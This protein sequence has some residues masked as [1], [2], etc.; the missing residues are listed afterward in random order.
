MEHREILK[1]GYDMIWLLSCVLNGRKPDEERLASMDPALLM[2]ESKRHQISA[3]IAKA[4]EGTS[5]DSPAW[6]N[7]LA[8]SMR[9][10]IL[11]TNER[12]H[13][14]DRLEENA[15]WYMPLKGSVLEKYYPLCGLRE[16]SDADIL[17]DAAREA[18]VKAIMKSEGYSVES[19]GKIHNDT[20][21]KKPI[22]NF[23]MHTSLFYENKYEKLY[24][25]YK[26]VKKRLIRDGQSEYGYCF[27][28]E[29]FYVFLLAHAYKHYS[30]E[31]FGLRLLADVF[32]YQEK[33][34]DLDRDYIRRQCEQL[35]FAEWSDNVLSLTMKAI[36]D[37]VYGDGIDG[38]EKKIMDHVIDS[39]AF[40]TASNTIGRKVREVHGEGKLTLA[41]KLKYLWSRL[42]MP[43][44]ALKMY[45]PYIYKHR[46]LRPFFVIYR[47]FLAVFTKRN[48]IRAEMHV[49]RHLDEEGGE[50][51]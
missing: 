45:H 3:L 49:L 32:V 14:L 12:K 43:E 44:E 39:R 42:I 16:M 37:G 34:P 25:Y 17:F 21:H 15:I 51:S 38:E 28:A 4:L 6:Q 30:H 20:Y 23:E 22:Y 2:K 11:F 9:R 47:F 19:Y 10:S 7:L 5:L 50:E 29:D 33:E 8:V 48:V 18:D 35:G 41:A 40:G 24:E 27:T 46:W 1:N 26:D 13:I 36:K 31:G